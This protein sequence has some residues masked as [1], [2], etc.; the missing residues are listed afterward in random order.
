MS[1][2]V[3]PTFNSQEELIIWYL[4]HSSEHIKTIVR[5]AILQEVINHLTVDE[6]KVRVIVE[7]MNLGEYLK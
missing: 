2:F 3:T 5:K 6:E 7:S 4:I 1:N